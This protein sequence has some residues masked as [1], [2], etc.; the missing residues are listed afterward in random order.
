M[1]LLS[2]LPTFDLGAILVTS[3]LRIGVA[4]SLASR[5]GGADRPFALSC[6]SPASYFRVA[7]SPVPGR[8]IGARHRLPLLAPRI[9][10]GCGCLQRVLG[11]G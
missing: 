6:P 11:A 1:I 7:M 2:F 4:S 3:A 10:E 5:G 8:V 9:P